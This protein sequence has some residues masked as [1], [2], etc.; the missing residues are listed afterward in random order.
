MMKW[1]RFVGIE[2]GRQERHGGA[3]GHVAALKHTYIFICTYTL[4][5]VYIYIYMYMDINTREENNRADLQTIE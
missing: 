3:A 5:N 1:N 2:G 4:T